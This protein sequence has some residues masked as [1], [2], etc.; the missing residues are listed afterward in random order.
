MGNFEGE[1]IFRL[2]ARFVSLVRRFLKQEKA[3]VKEVGKGA[4]KT[5]VPVLA[6]GGACIVLVALAAVFS[7]VTIVLLLNTWFVPWVSAL[8]VTAS[9]MFTGLLLGG[10]ALVMAKKGAREARKHL[11]CVQEDMRWLKRS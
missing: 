10:T 5:G 2:I 1:A 6:L 3:Y 9:L 7:L 11:S 8:I 4:L